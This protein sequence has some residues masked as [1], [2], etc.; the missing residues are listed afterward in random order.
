LKEDC[1]LTY[2]HSFLLEANLYGEKDT[3][4]YPCND[5]N[6]GWDDLCKSCNNKK[7]TE[8]ETDYALWFDPINSTNFDCFSEASCVAPN[9]FLRTVNA[10]ECHNC[11]ELNGGNCL[12]CNG[13]NNCTKCNES[14]YHLYKTDADN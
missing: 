9:L 14:D 4:C 11:T 10:S 13:D 5:T 12:E 8:C 3:Y 7:C 1:D 2:N 6:H